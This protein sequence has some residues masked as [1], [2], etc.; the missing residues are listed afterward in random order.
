MATQSTYR[1]MRT[2]YLLIR[3]MKRFRGWFIA[4]GCVF[5]VLGVLAIAF[6]WIATLSL[7]LTIGTLF[8]IAGI[9]QTIHSFYISRWKGFAMNLMLAT[10]ALVA[11]GLMLFYPMAGV[12]TL[13]SLVMVYFLLTGV[14]KTGFALQVRPALGWGWILTSGLL[15]LALGVLILIQLVAFVPWILGLLLGVD[16][17]F[18]GFWI[19]LLAVKAGQLIV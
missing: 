11:G 6:P 8:V 19:L 15:S 5:L 9:A 17:L 2:Q 13:T 14:V 18:T 7:E 12:V 3:D 10:L 1:H 4:L 16:F